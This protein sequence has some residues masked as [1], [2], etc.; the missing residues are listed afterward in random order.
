MWIAVTIIAI[1]VILV[2]IYYWIYNQLIAARETVAE[3]FATIDVQLKKRFD[4]IPRLVDITK[5][6]SKYES[7]LL[8]K[9]T[10]LRSAGSKE[11]LIQREKED[12]GLNLI[13]SAIKM[14]VEDYPELKANEQFNNLMQELSKVE[15]ELAMSR[16]YYN[17]A[18]RDFNTK[19]DMF[20]H[21]LVS[22]YLNYTER[23]FYEIEP[24]ER[25]PQKLFL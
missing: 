20:P 24:F 14:R 17:G 22:R 25:E 7:E 16:R 1:I 23:P 3:A 6:Y 5:S 15:D 4:L 18:I 8:S 12:A 2:I 21:V 11:D 13:S 9:V 10:E 19:I